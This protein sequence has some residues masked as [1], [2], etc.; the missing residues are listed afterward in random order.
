MY[1]TRLVQFPRGQYVLAAGRPIGNRPQDDILPYKNV[2][3]Y[4]VVLLTGLY[5]TPANGT[6][7][8][9]TLGV[10]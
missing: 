7:P 8:A 10:V 4:F 6:I 5:G 3:C 1:G 9:G 2:R